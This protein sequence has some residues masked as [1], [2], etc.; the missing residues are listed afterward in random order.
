MEKLKS[1]ALF[2]GPSGSSLGPNRLLN[3]GTVDRNNSTTPVLVRS[4]S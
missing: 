4:G 3:D 1:N 2:V